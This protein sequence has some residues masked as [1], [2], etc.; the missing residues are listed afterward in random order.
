MTNPSGDV[1][2]GLL[3]FGPPGTGKTTL[4]KHL[5]LAGGFELISEPFPGG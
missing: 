4:T 2:R 5:A 3:L 1:C